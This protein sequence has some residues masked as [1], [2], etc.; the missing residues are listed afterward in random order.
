[1]SI[2]PKPKARLENG[3]KVSAGDEENQALKVVKMGENGGQRC[4]CVLRNIADG[5]RISK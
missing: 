1:M 5:E 2:W 4:A 3:K